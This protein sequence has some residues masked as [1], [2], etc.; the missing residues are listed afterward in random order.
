M[1]YIVALARLP[2]SISEFWSRAL[3]DGLDA[4][5]ARGGFFVKSGS[6]GLTASIVIVRRK[7]TPVALRFVM[8]D[9]E[10]RVAL[11]HDV[12]EAFERGQCLLLVPHIGRHD[13]LVPT[14]LKV[15]YIS[16]EQHSAG[17]GQL[18]QQ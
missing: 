4:L 15:D 6:A 5:L 12:G 2:Y 7:P 13:V 8:L 1:P 3:F 11:P 9:P 14:V 10:L 18:Y 17:P 16:A